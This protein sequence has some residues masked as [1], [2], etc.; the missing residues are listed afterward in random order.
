MHSH[1]DHPHTK[2]LSNDLSLILRND[3][4]LTAQYIFQGEILYGFSPYRRLEHREARLQRDRERHREARSDESLEHREARLQCDRESHRESYREQRMQGIPLFQQHSV[5]TKM[6]KFHAHFATMELLRCSTCSEAFPGLHLHPGSSECVP[7]GRD[8]RTPKLY[9]TG[10]N[11]DP[12]QLKTSTFGLMYYNW[13]LLLSSA[14]YYVSCPSTLISG[15]VTVSTHTPLSAFLQ[16][17]IF[18]CGNIA[19]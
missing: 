4:I 14:I 9:S 3:F 1:L 7:C 17:C 12:G 11:M 15:N 8:K 5:Q 10:N 19:G 18:G 2:G 13:S 6:L 16:C